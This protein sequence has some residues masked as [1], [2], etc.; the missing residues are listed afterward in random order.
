MITETAIGLALEAEAFNSPDAG[1][2]EPEAVVIK[3]DLPI[4]RKRS[5]PQTQILSR[6]RP[7]HGHHRP[8]SF[9][10]RASRFC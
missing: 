8:A 1:Q 4:A 7:R 3:P 2:T 5:G 9:C 10:F 6:R